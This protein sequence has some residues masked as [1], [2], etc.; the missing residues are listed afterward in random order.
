MACLY[1]NDKR[2]FNH[3]IF[4]ILLILNCLLLLWFIAQT[5]IYSQE[6]I[7]FFHFQDSHANLGREFSAAFCYKLAF[8]GVSIVQWLGIHAIYNDFGLR[9]P[10]LLLHICN[11]V[12]LY[13]IALKMLRKAQ[14]SLLCVGI[15]MLIPGISV[16]ALVV[17]NTSV[18][19]FLSLLII[20][21]QVIHNRIAYPLFVVAIFL[22]SGG[23]ILCLALFFYALY[24][25]KNKTIIFAILCFGIN[26]YLFAPIYGVPK[27]YFLDTI[28]FLAIIFTPVF[29]VYYC[30]YL[31]FYTLHNTPSFVNVIAFIGFI[32]VLLLSIRQPIKADSFIPFLVVGIPVF[33][34]KMQTE[35]RV[36]LPQFRIK[37]LIRIGC[38]ASFLIF[39][40]I[41]LFGNKLTYY[42]SNEH[43]FAY[44]F[45]AAKEIAKELYAKN[46]THIQVEGNLG[47]R[48]AFYGINTDSTAP[49][50]LIQ[51]RNGNINIVYGKHTVAQYG[52]IRQ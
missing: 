13:I 12:L 42:F 41:I 50:Q 10:F 20:Y 46:I 34:D 35:L 43:N 25:R 28:G 37:Y 5:S 1:L 44:P 21:W 52:I 49:Y 16:S 36:R 15:F 26:M 17:S 47:I 29:F 9:A 51:I 30:A 11:C 14:D 6:A 7:R 2:I 33:V 32:F 23:S 4:C 48:L 40:N 27:S 18:L 45:Y 22:D 39:G 31:Y 3:L 38:I 24:Y 19:I 8:I